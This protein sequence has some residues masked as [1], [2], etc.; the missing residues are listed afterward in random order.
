MGVFRIT[1]VVVAIA[2]SVLVT[3]A[4][5][6]DIQAGSQAADEPA[7]MDSQEEGAPAGI[8]IQEEGAP[9]GIDIQ[10]EGASVGMDIQE[11]G[12]RPYV[13]DDSDD[14]MWAEWSKLTWEEY[15]VENYCPKEIHLD[16][17]LTSGSMRACVHRYLDTVIFYF[18]GINTVNNFSVNVPYAFLP[19]VTS[20]NTFAFYVHS[21]S[22]TATVNNQ[23]SNSQAFNFELPPKTTHVAVFFNTAIPAS[24]YNDLEPVAEFYYRNLQHPMPCNGNLIPVPKFNGT[25]VCIMP[26]ILEA[27]LLGHDGPIDESIYETI[28]KKY[29]KYSCSKDTHIPLIKSY[30]SRTICATP[31]E[32]ER[33]I[34][35][36]GW[37]GDY[38]LSDNQY[39]LCKSMICD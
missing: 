18:D 30:P 19:P 5:Y 26:I 22:G 32:A 39:L 13:W 8:D 36:K 34:D 35:S 9:A 10:E 15:N 2:A 12:V 16:Y 4:L 14:D 23:T 27:I 21:S 7:G 20:H 25:S 28:I 31:T 1:A 37:M 29:E 24:S 33:L 38:T 11:E 6:Y 3:T 17:E